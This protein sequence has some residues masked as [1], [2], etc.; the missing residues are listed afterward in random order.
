MSTRKMV[1]MPIVSC[2]EKAKGVSEE[3]WSEHSCLWVGGE[4]GRGCHKN[5]TADK[6]LLSAAQLRAGEDMGQVS[7]GSRSEVKGACNLILDLAPT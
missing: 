7:W 1:E 3:N 6:T 5:K 4:G 2:R